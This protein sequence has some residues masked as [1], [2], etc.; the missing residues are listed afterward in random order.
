LKYAVAVARHLSFTRAAT[1]VSVA[2][3]ALSQQIAALERELGVRL[4]D[5]TNR[6]VSLTDA[7]RAF[8]MHAERILGD[9]ESASEEMTSY[10][11]GLR[12]RVVVGTYQSFAEYT[13]PK[14]LGRFHGTHPRIEVALREGM[15]DE[16]LAG[17]RTGLIDVFVG[18]LVETYPGAE[19]E[20]DHAPLYED[21]LAI[22]VASSHPLAARSSVRIEELRDEPFVI[23][24]PG[25][26]MTQRLNALARAAGFEPRVAFES[27]DSLTVRSLVAERLGVALFPR[28][29]GNTPGPNIAL[30]SLAPY[31][32][33]RRMSIVTRKTPPSPSAQRF[34]AFIREEQYHG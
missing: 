16:L 8:L 2:Q 9:L 25:S 23:F 32:L 19:H 12:G 11:G 10:A 13:L 14:V 18:D 28:T 7:G 17:L 15:A 22:A 29:L 6:R 26:Q 5:R 27:V 31:P 30:V 4:F 1:A 24:R 20:F 3:P 33:L 34:I 21:E